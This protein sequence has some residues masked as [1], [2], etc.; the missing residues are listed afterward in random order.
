MQK[1]H[2]LQLM[3]KKRHECVEIFKELICDRLTKISISVTADAMDLMFLSPLCPHF[4]PN[5]CVE[6]LTYL[7][8]RYLG[9]NS[10]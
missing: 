4:P 1:T 9:S 6:A 2:N 7:E 5:P 10:G 8:I 3:D